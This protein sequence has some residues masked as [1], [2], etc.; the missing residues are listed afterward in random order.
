M[1]EPADFPDASIDEL[2]HWLAT[3]RQ[4]QP[5]APLSML[6]GQYA[7]N[8]Q[9]L[10]DLVCIDLM[11]RR[12]RQQ[13]VRVEDYLEE[14][15]GLATASHLLDLI[16]AEVCVARELN[17][18]VEL[19]AYLDRFPAVADQVRELFL[20]EAGDDGRFQCTDFSL[21]VLP[22]R[23]ARPT[24]ISSLPRH[25]L[26]LPDWFVGERCVA[27]GPGRWLIRGRD[28]ARGDSLALKVTELPALI[29]PAQRQ[30]VLDA[31][32]V[33]ASVH[34]RN[35]VSP[36]VAA[37]QQHHLGV[38]RPWLFAH[39][40][41]SGEASREVGTQLRQFATVAFTIAAA[42]QVGATHGGIHAENLLIDHQ[43]RVQVVDGASSRLGVQRWLSPAAP[44]AAAE[45]GGFVSLPQ[46]KRIDIQDLIKLVAAA[47]VGWERHWAR[48]LVAEL[49]GA[50]EGAVEDACGAIGEVLTRHADASI[51]PAVPRSVGGQPPGSWRRRLA[52]WLTGQG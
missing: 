13:A 28:S 43:G 51:P 5:S 26:D 1:S 50:G 11:H 31:C 4:Q 20:L 18:S 6:L 10:V 2:M 40:W 35:W 44:L 47:A 49:R 17:E 39:S 8:S 33:A 9:R 37:I 52:R 3:R 23:S 16:D 27:S 41:Q 14:F 29:S 12:R 32:E 25:P 42:H 15:P 30:S 24:Q 48:D 7:I 46:R 45:S 19:A 22:R 34:N 36:G 21:E 38:I